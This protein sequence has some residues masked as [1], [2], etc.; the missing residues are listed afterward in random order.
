MKKVQVDVDLFKKYYLDQNLPIRTCAEL[1]GVSISTINRCIKTNGICKSKDLIYSSVANTNLER[2]G[3]VNVWQAEEVKQKIKQT[4]LDV[5][6][7]DNP[8][9]ADCIKAKAQKTCLERYGVEYTTKVPDFIAKKEQTNLAR[10]GSVSALSSPKVRKKINETNII[11][12]GVASQFQ[13]VEVKEKVKQTNLDK[14]GVINQFQAAD[15]KNKAW[16]KYTYNELKFDSTW[17]LA[18]YIYAIDHNEKIIRE[19]KR[20]SYIVEGKKHFYTPDFWYKNSFID[21]KG[22][23]LLKDGLIVDPYGKLS[24]QELFAKNECI[25][26]NNVLLMTREDISFAFNYVNEKYGKKYLKQFKN[27]KT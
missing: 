13:R 25:K 8:A 14:Y 27:I 1:L 16:K 20:F 11:R 3:V 10:Y 5:Y 7:V 26:K 2:Y 17:E 21:I 19:P 18:L 9:K 6:G 12:Y 15:F 4:S 24:E 23:H 22:D